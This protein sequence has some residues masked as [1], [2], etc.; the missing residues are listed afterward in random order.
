MIPDL[1]DVADAARRLAPFIR[2]TPVLG[3]S[4]LNHWSGLDMRFKYENLQVT[5]SFKARGAANAVMSLSAETRHVVAHSS[6]NHGAALAY[7]A[8]ARSIPATIVM[9]AVSVETKK[10]NVRSFGGRIV[11]CGSSAAERS[12]AVEAILAAEGGTL[13]H[14]YNDAQVIAG[15]GTCLLEFQEQAG[16]LDAVVVPIG[17]GGLTSGSCIAA[18][19]DDR[20]TKVFAAEPQQADDA[21]KSLRAG[22]LVDPDTPDTIADGLRAPL[23]ELT[24]EIISKGVEDVLTVEEIEIVEAMGIFR[25]YTGRLIEPS[26]AVA[27]AAALKHRELFQGLRL[28][29]I[30]TGGNLEIDQL[31]GFARDQLK[32]MAASA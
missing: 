24:W 32:A 30:I 14:P 13:V 22:R 31:P 17:G 27:L 29:I 8:K 16:H 10:Q 2:R 3:F 7:A 12:A 19:V 20:R 23:L 25:H 26:S 9:P 11:E 21:H 28:G 6:G 18:G 15:Q 5:G 4:G 1:K